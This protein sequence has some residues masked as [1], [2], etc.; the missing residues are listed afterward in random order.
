MFLLLNDNTVFE[1]NIA[2]INDGHATFTA[3]DNDERTIPLDRIIS[4]SDIHP[5]E[6]NLAD[7]IEE[8]EAVPAPEA[9][10]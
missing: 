9:E 1:T 3:T 8:P 7:D 5:L 4:M 2:T 10:L 6:A